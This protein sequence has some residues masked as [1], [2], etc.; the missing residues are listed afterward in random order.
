[1][2]TYVDF[3]GSQSTPSAILL[4]TGLEAIKNLTKQI[5]MIDAKEMTELCR[6]SSSLLESGW[7]GITRGV[8]VILRTDREFGGQ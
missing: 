2:S 7:L 5:A 3:I 8:T 6:S 4:D 1:M